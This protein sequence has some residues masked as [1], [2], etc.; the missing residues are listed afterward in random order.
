MKTIDATPT[1]SAVVSIYIQVLLNPKAS[2][3]SIMAAKK[4]LVNV[5]KLADAYVKAAKGIEPIE[6]DPIEGAVTLHEQWLNGRIGNFGSFQ[7]KLFDAFTQADGGNKAKLR[8]AFPYWFR[9]HTNIPPR[10]VEGSYMPTKKEIAAFILKYGYEAVPK[11]IPVSWSNVA[12]SYIVTD[13]D[14][15]SEQER[16]LAE[17]LMQH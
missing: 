15:W 3:D 11:R 12:D 7:T 17:Y 1:W 13:C 2:D 6:L 4:E 10:I 9:D 14:E 5:A 16:K 8:A